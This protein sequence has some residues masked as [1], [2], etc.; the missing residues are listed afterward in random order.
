MKSV[1]INS[2]DPLGIDKWIHNGQTC[3]NIDLGLEKY[4]KRI[5]EM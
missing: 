2:S 5:N 1:S 4:N 3:N